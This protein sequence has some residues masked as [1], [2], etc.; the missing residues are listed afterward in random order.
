MPNQE[1]TAAVPAPTE[2]APQRGENM[3]HKTLYNKLM[4]ALIQV[5]FSAGQQDG[6]YLEGWI[7]AFSAY[8]DALIDVLNREEPKMEMGIKMI[9]PAQPDKE[10]PDHD[11]VHHPRHYTAGKIE[12][13][14][15]QMSKREK[16]EGDRA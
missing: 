11:A 9:A 12:V 15:S 6:R 3:E 2:D 7:N 14:S 10:Q 1:N 16:T 4:D 5:L 13:I 8:E